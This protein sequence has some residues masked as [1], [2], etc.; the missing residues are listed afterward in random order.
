MIKKL[1]L[2]FIAFFLLLSLKAQQFKKGGYLSEYS[3]GNVYSIHYENLTH[4]FAAFIN[5]DT[6]GNLSFPNNINI[7]VNAAHNKGCKVIPSFGGGGDY[8]WGADT[9]IYKKLIDANHRTAF[10]HKM[11]D[12]VRLHN[13]DGI[14]LDL[15][16]QALQLANYN[17]FAQETA[18]SVHAAGLEI[19]AALAI[20]WQNTWAN[21]IS[22]ATLQ[23]LDF[24]MT[25][26]YGGVG[27]W[28]YNTPSDQF[29]YSDFVN[30]I[31]YW[32]SRG[33]SKEQILGGIGFYGAE[34]PLTAQSSYWQ[35]SPSLCSIFTNSAYSSQNPLNSDLV[36]TASN[37]PVYY[38]G[39]PTLKKKIQYAAANAGGFMIWELG[40]DC[41]SG[42]I[43]IL[44]SLQQYTSEALNIIELQ[45]IKTLE[46]FPNPADNLVHLSNLSEED[47]WRIY[48]NIGQLIL[49]GKGKT[50]YI[51]NLNSGFYNIEAW[52]N[53]YRMSAKML[54]K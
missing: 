38:N 13:L 29:A 51:E 18:D 49:E 3:F 1:L 17:A 43:R 36:Y 46:L 16:G 32:I 8:S 7:L 5:P 35:Y 54:K 39:F 14:D 45:E 9:L 50:C 26:S 19:S 42:N 24:I 21:A 47:Q 31:N 41:F 33:L 4:V 11:M 22:N 52:H 20:G 30:D 15:E 34:F 2:I 28:N 23:K 6:A 44:D 53:K 10:I 27:S 12:Y 40:N 25:M 37:H 48:N